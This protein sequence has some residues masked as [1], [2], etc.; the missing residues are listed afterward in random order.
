MPPVALGV[1]GHKYREPY[2]PSTKAASK[3]KK[4]VLVLFVFVCLLGRERFL[5]L[6]L[7]LFCYF[8]HRG[9]GS[10]ELGV[11]RWFWFCWCWKIHFTTTFISE[12]QSPGGFA[13]FSVVPP[14]APVL[15]FC[16]V[17]FARAFPP[18]GASFFC[19][20]AHQIYQMGKWGEY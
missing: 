5:V 13:V 6:I 8:L 19:E 18:R 10:G 17:S 12:R 1:R 2:V 9:S 11:V 15:P 14:C 3:K 20:C 4:R 7:I 16:G